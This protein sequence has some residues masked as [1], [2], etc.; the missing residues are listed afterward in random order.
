MAENPHVTITQYDE[1]INA[2]YK[3]AVRSYAE[4]KLTKE[5]A[6]EQFKADVSNAYPDLKVQ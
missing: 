2:A 6:I 5:K 1:Q 3:S 4:G